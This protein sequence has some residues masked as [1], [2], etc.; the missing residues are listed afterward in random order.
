[1]T[2]SLQVGVLCAAISLA[3]CGGSD[4]PSVSSPKAD[5]PAANG[6]TADTRG[7][8]PRAASDSNSTTRGQDEIWTD[9]NGNKFI[10]KVPY[11]AFFDDTYVIASDTTPL[12]GVPGGESM[13]VDTDIAG[14]TL[15]PAPSADPSD[16]PPTDTATDVAS[17]SWNDLLSTTVIESEI[18]AVRNF[19]NQ[20][21]QAVGSYNSSMLMIPPK[22]ATL[23]VLS[24]IAAEHSGDITWKDDAGY[25]QDLAKKMNESALQR[26]PKDQRRLLKLFLAL[27]DTLNRSRPAGLD[28]PPEDDTFVDIAEMRLVMMRMEEAKNRL[29]TEISENSLSEKKELVQH[30]AAILATFTRAISDESYGFADDPD[31]VSHANDVIRAAKELIGS[32]EANDFESFGVALSGVSSSCQACHSVYKNN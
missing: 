8:S 11:D 21:L 6:Q 16:Q 7:E 19:L 23:A 10:G 15:R 31:F 12:Q 24:K 27:A 17:G 32:A 22:A 14:N 29:T 1:M 25:V 4:P 2:K 3:G 30:E 26:G 9:E 5:V 13:N 18:K 20:N 28:D